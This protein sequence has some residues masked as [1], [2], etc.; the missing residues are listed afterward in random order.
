MLLDLN[1][2]RVEHQEFVM[3]LDSFED[4]VHA[5]HKGKSPDYSL[6]LEMIDAT[7]L[8]LNR[9]HRRTEVLAWERLVERAGRPLLTLEVLKRR[10]AAVADAR[11]RVLT[12]IR[13]AKAGVIAPRADVDAGARMYI[14][15]LRDQI[16]FEEHAVFPLISRLFDR[17]DWTDIAH[18]SAVV[19]CTA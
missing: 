14:E 4:E 19:R 2:L 15:R 5:F 10:I 9:C 12:L 16:A 18:R 6:W 8:D 7:T 3:L 1:H 17:R 13:G 11:Q